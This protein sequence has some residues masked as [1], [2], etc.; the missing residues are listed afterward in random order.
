[1]GDQLPMSVVIDGSRWCRDS[2][3]GDVVDVSKRFGEK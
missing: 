3:S 1:M 2:C